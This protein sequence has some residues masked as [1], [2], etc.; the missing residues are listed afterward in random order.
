MCAGYV[1]D[2]EDES[3]QIIGNEDGDSRVTMA[4]GNIV[5]I[6]GG[7]NDGI[8]PGD[9]FYTQRRDRKV[10]A[11]WQIT[12]TGWLTVLAAQEQNAIAEPH[13]L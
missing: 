12:R 3:L 5:Y 6:N 9:V 2:K 11:G 13:V 7:I 1:T 10:D 8:S 4:T